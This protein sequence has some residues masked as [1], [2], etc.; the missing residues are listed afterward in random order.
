M[1]D[2]EE[3]LEDLL[4]QFIKPMKGIPFEVVIRSLCGRKVNKIDI[5]NPAHSEVINQLSHVAFVAGSDAAKAGIVRPRPNEV[6]NDMES[7]VLA[8]AKQLGVGA[9]S[10]RTASGG[11]LEKLL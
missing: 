6:G 1:T 10:P 3:Q 11:H 5:S 8:A 7:F 4:A 9:I 2:R